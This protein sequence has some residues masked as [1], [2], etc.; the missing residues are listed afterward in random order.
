MSWLKRLLG[1]RQEDLPPAEAFATPRVSLPARDR[2]I[3]SIP[4]LDFVG[5]R[6][7]SPNGRYTLLWHDRRWFEGKPSDG[8]YVLIDGGAVV[9]DEVMERPQDGKVADDGTFILN[10]WGASAELAGTF[11]AFRADGSTIVSRLYSANLL[12][13]GLSLDGRQAVCQT[14][15]APGS[16]DSSILTIF[17]LAAG[18]ELTRWTAESGW[19]NGYEFPEGGQRIRML[20]HERPPLDYSLA[21]EF[22][23]RRLWLKDE[24]QRG[25]LYA[26]RKALA[27]GEAATGVSAEALRQGARRLIAEDERFRAE[28]WRLLGE[29][30]ESA[31]RNAAALEAYDRALGFNP[32]IGVAKRAAALRKAAQ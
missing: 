24:V 23:D 7:D 17:N 32:R 3:V 26:L 2:E 30:E 15:N 9:V 14:C 19:A 10:D 28:G 8:R 16:P 13:N 22:L 31:G 18:T 1:A 20:R 29:I 25:T 4:E 21:G 6:I 5:H 27:E 12:N 11:H